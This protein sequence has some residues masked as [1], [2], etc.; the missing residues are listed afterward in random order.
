MVKGMSTVKENTR[1]EELLSS[2]ETPI[3]DEGKRVR[4]LDIFGKD[5]EFLRAISDPA[6]DIHAITN[7]ELQVILKGTPWAKNMTGKQLSGRI[8]RHLALLRKHGLIEKLPNQRKYLLT[9]KG[10]KIAAALNVALAASVE[11]L[12]KLAA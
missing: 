7:K 9:D 10:S 12:L 4:A 3:V 6:L 2:V 8:S 5:K 11:G 1:L